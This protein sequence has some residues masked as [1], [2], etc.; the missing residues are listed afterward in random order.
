MTAEV[1][2]HVRATHGGVELRHYPRHVTADVEVRASADK[3]GNRA[4]RTLASYINGQNRAKQSLAMTAPVLQ[5]SG[6]RL[7]MT[8]P[9][10][11]ESLQDELWVISFVLPESRPLAQYPEP[12]DDRITLREVPAHESAAIK[13]T[14]RWTYRSVEEHTQELLDVMRR[15]KWSASGT[16]IWA[17]YDPPWKPFFLRRNE[18]LIHVADR[19]TGD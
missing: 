5:E 16:P 2:Y 11:Q 14:G 18:V 19:E 9:V 8:A 4:F 1:P 15:M 7:A 17:R 3:A 10:L 6:E 12:L 13:W